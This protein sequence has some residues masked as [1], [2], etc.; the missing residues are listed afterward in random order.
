MGDTYKKQ[1]VKNAQKRREI[2]AREAAE[3]R[4]NV[5]VSKAEMKLV[6]MPGTDADYTC[7]ERLAVL[8][9]DNSLKVVRKGFEQIGH[10]EGEAAENLRNLFAVN[11][12]TNVIQVVVTDV[13]ALSGVAN[14]EILKGS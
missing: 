12:G 4:L 14:A 13:A 8:A 6:L 1:Q 2:A 5:N 11:G 9:G 7:G 3:P 10:V